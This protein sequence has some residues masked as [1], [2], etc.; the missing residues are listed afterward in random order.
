VINI[1]IKHREALGIVAALLLCSLYTLVANAEINPSPVTDRADSPSIT[2]QK[3]PKL[4][5]SMELK[6]AHATTA[7]AWSA[8][9]TRL[10]AYSDYGQLVT[11]WDKSGNIIKSMEQHAGGP[12]LGSSLEFL[13]DRNILLTSPA[14]RD[15]PQDE[16]VSLSVWDIQQGALVRT[17]D[18]PDSTQDWRSNWADRFVTTSDKSS[19]ATVTYRITTPYVSI[20]STQTGHLIRNI[21]VGPDTGPAVESAQSI[22]FSHDDHYLA[23]GTIRGKVLL[24]DA[25][26]GKLLR[27]IQ[28][29]GHTA[30][31]VYALAFSPDGRFVATGAGIPI[32]AAPS[33]FPNDPQPVVPPGAGPVRV[34][35]ISDGRYAA[36]YPGDKMNPIRKIAWAPTGLLAFVGNDNTVRLWNPDYER[37]TAPTVQFNRDVLSLAFSPD[38]TH[39]AVCDGKQVTVIEI[40]NK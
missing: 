8:D 19:V 1:T 13:K 38:G 33:V 37:E 30:A 17:I 39:L 23:V 21:P 5:I 29:Y 32:I 3:M 14:V 35:R 2:D 4:H 18:G 28:A 7:V 40:G 16:H 31:G 11:V 25:G 36:S 15:S 10:A 22:V 6:F 12:Y 24:F 9:G 34:W 20:F 27:T 26:S